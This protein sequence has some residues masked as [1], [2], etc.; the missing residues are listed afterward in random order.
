MPMSTFAEY[1]GGM[2]RAHEYARL[3]ESMLTHVPGTFDRIGG[4]MGVAL[5]SLIRMFSKDS[6]AA[7]F[8]CTIGRKH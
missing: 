6:A 3:T 4:G 1:D 5:G 7:M 2:Q 8:S